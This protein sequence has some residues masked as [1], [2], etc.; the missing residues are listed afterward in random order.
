M[1]PA[2]T[3]TP[4]SGNDFISHAL[5]ERGNLYFHGTGDVK[6]FHHRQQTLDHIRD[7]F[8]R[9][10]LRTPTDPSVDPH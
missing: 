2:E 4:F 6:F 10:A 5:R 1:N 9:W 8:I 7:D 3:T